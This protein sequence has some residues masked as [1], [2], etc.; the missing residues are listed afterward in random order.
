MVIDALQTQNH[1]PLIIGIDDGH[2]LDDGSLALLA[3]VASSRT[4]GDARRHGPSRLG[5]RV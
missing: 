5:T 3:T 4:N 2:Q 1:G